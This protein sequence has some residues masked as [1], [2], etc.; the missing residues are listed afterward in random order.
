MCPAGQVGVLAGVP[1]LGTCDYT[2][3]FTSH[4]VTETQKTDWNSMAP[5]DS[6]KTNGYKGRD[7]LFYSDHDP[8]GQTSM[9]HRCPIKSNKHQESQKGMSYDLALTV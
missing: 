7:F 8:K 3:T 6:G 9:H 1:S 4:M 2:V 5:G